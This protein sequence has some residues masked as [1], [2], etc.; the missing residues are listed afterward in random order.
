VQ[1]GGWRLGACALLASVACACSSGSI[2]TP[3][4]G[5]DASVDATTPAIDSAAPSADAFVPPVDA[6]TPSDAPANA[7]A[8]PEAGTSACSWD[9]GYESPACSACLRAACCA[10]AMTCEG[11]PACVALDQCVSGCLTTDGGGDAG[12][13]STCAQACADARTP[14][15]RS[16]W[17]A[18]S[19]C[20]EFQCSGS[21]AGPCQ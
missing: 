1:D 14:A 4:A 19:N 8:A 20:V 2:A 5:E 12:S 6:G 11:D 16:E 15:V 13:I 7:D 21:G 3:N 18:L 10:A 9:G 17:Q